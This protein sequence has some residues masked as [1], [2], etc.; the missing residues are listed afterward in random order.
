M[1]MDFPRAEKAFSNACRMIEAEQANAPMARDSAS[2]LS[3]PRVTNSGK[4]GQ[5]HENRPIEALGFSTNVS[6]KKL[7]NN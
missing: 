5:S 6:T 7:A 2:S 4:S 3:W 1:L